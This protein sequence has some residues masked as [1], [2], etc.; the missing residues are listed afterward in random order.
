MYRKAFELARS[1]LILY[2][3]LYLGG[4]V[5]H[6][7]PIGIPSSIWGLLLLF[8]CLTL[9]IVK[10]EWVIFSSRLLI[11]YMALLF[12]PVSVGIVKYSGLLMD[13]MKELLLPNIVSTCVT[14]VVIGL[15]SDY[16]FSLKSF[17]HLKHKIMK[18][19]AKEE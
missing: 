6:Y 19:R 1:L 12:V 4:L 16:L 8:T 14:L 15:L 13:Q 3:I 9:R 17:T 5:A 11:R 2:L 10:V 7:V 18:K